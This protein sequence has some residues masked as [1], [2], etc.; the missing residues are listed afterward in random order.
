M[1]NKQ[2]HRLARIG[3]VAAMLL[4]GGCASSEIVPSS[5]PRPPTTPDKVSLYSH[6]PKKYEILGTVM[7]PV[8]TDAHWDQSGNA[9]AGFDR[10]KAAAAERGANGLLMEAPTGSYDNR[11]LAGYH[12]TFYQVPFRSNPRSAVAQAI[13]V[14]E[15]K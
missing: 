4:A 8:A 12:G 7:I 3:A 5:G 2:L 15:E 14:L 10:L 6:A 13:W 11:V 1:N 9:D